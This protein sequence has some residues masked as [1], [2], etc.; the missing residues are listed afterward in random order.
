MI[1]GKF[2]TID[3]Y[4]RDNENTLFY[5]SLIPDYEVYK[6]H[7]P[8]KPIAP[9]VFNIQMIKECAEET[10]HK[11]L[12]LKNIAQC[13]FQSLIIPTDNKYLIVEIQITEKD[14]EYRIISIIKDDKNIFIQFKGDFVEI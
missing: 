11:K 8:G 10:L 9:G 2:F 3:S 6:G 4:K 12:F 5:V 14:N 1:K 7:F 13:R